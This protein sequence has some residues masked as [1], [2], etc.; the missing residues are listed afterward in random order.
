MLRRCRRRESAIPS[1]CYS[2][3]QIMDVPESD[4]PR[5]QSEDA[6]TVG[7]VIKYVVLICLLQVSVWRPMFFYFLLFQSAMMVLRSS[8]NESLPAIV[9]RFASSRSSSSYEH[10]VRG[11]S[12]SRIHDVSLE[13]RCLRPPAAPPRGNILNCAVFR[14]QIPVTMALSVSCKM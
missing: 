14:C 6:H 5:G 2:G 7:M 11:R 4:A 13:R 8:H 1:I 12:S 9:R 10:C 3:T